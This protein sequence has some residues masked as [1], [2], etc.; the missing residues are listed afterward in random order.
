MRI[1]LIEKNDVAT[2]NAPAYNSPE[3]D[4]GDTR[5][6]RLAESEEKFEV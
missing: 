6:K 2:R 4:A 3:F 5:T 1:S